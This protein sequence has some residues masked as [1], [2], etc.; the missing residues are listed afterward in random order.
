MKIDSYVLMCIY[1]NYSKNGKLGAVNS[2]EIVTY[3]RNY[4]KSDF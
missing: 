2:P 1:A 4:T 3:C